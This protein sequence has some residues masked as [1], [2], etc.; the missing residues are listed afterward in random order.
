MAR[1]NRLTMLTMLLFA[2]QPLPTEAAGDVSQG[3]NFAQRVCAGCHAIQP[4]LTV[5]PVVAAPTFPAI[6]ASPGMSPI[7]LRVALQ[8]THRTMPNLALTA[9]ELDDVIA[10]IIGL[11]RR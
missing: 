7:A 9:D 2:A 4:G 11:Q 3:R 10:Y 5:S 8:S 1:V 6:A